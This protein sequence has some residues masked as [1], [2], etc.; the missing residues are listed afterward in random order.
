M[1]R[2]SVKVGDIFSVKLDTH[3]KYF[4][5]VSNDSTQ[6]NSDVIRGFKKYY[7][8]EESPTPLDIVKGEVEFYAHCNTKLGV[9]MELWEKVG[10]EKEIG[11][12]TNVL[13]RSAADYGRKAGEEPVKI[14][15]KWYVW[16]IND[17]EA[18]YIGKL[19]E[20][21][22]TAYIGLI[23]NPKGI[24]ELLKGNKYPPEYPG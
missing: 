22:K 8:T 19:E 4:Q 9:K 10:T 7:S 23:I 2:V 17:K 16:K 5:Y 18:T 24:V 20:Q 6:L 15:S 1:T 13:F 3:K 21:F 14:S 12:L 11:D